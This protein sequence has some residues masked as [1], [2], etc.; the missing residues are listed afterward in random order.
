MLLDNGQLLA[1]DWVVVAGGA[2]ASELLPDLP[3]RSRQGHLLITERGGP[4][5][6]APAHRTRLPEERPRQRRRLGGLQRAAAPQRSTADRQQPPVRAHQPGTRLAAAAPDAGPRR[7]IPAGAARRPA[8]CASGRAS[9]PPRPI[10]CRSSDRI[11][12]R[13]GVYLALGHE[14]L[15]ITAALGTAELLAARSWAAR[16]RRSRPTISVWSASRGRLSM[17]ELVL[18]VEGQPLRVPAGVSVLAALQGAQQLSLRRSLSGQRRGALCGM[19]AASSAGARV[20]GGAAFAP[21]RSRFS[22]ACL[23]SCSNDHH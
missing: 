23:W 17:P 1:A 21:A 5:V 6:R 22:R 3:L 2:G 14:G 11:R 15:G 8:P 18:T 20:D 7:R 13:P 12:Q 19:G 4:R 16:P 9:A 10:T